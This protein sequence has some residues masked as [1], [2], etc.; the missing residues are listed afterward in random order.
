M[1]SSTG[2]EVIWEITHTGVKQLTTIGWNCACCPHRVTPDGGRAVTGSSATAAWQELYKDA[3][4]IE[5][6]SAK[7]SALAVAARAASVCGPR[8]FG[9]QQPVIGAL[10]ECLPDAALCENFLAW[11]STPPAAQPMVRYTTTSCA[12]EL[13]NMRT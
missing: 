3:P 4:P 5:G 13:K 9:L 7:A 2:S 8:L 1:Q 6:M 11:K 12:P 10:I